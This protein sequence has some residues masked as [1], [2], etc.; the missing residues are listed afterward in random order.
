MAVIA[1]AT[2]VVVPEDPLAAHYVGQAVLEV[3]GSRGHGR[4]DPPYD[5]LG[6]GTVGIDDALTDE[7]LGLPP[8]RPHDG[9]SCHHFPRESIALRLR[10]G[11]AGIGVGVPGRTTTL[12]HPGHLVVP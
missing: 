11:D 7:Q 6:Q 8:P 5:H 3:M 1:L 12:S 4:R 2:L 9:G 10:V